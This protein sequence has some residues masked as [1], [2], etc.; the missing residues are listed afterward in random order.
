MLSST[1]IYFISS[2][3][4]QPTLPEGNIVDYELDI[5]QKNLVLKQGRVLM[6]F[7]YNKNCTECEEKISFLESFANEYKDKTFLEKISV[8]E[9]KPKLHFIGFNVSENRIYLQ[10]RFLEEENI[11]EENTKKVLCEIMLYPPVECVGV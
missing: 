7:F 1:F 10:E 2:F 6:E 5:Q 4:F 9:G 11:T 3:L 8:I